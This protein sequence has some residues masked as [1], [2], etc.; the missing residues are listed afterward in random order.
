[1]DDCRTLYLNLIKRSLLNMIYGDKEVIYAAPRGQVKRILFSAIRTSG[2]EVV[3]P[4]S[5][6]PAV[7]A[8]GGD[9]PT[10][11]QTM[12][13]MARL[14]NIQYC[15]ETVLK[16]A[17]P[18]DL[19]ET[20]VW[21]GGATIFM[22]ALLKAYSVTDRLV[23][24]ADSFEGLPPADEAKYPQDAGIPYHTMKELMISLEKVQAN[25]ARYELLDDQVKFLKGWFRDTLPTAPM[26]QLAVMRLDGDMYESTMDGLN[27]LYPKLSV[28]GFVIIDDYGMLEPCRQAVDDY[29]AQ[30]GIQETI[31]KIDFAGVFW[32]RLA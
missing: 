13:S 28:G 24:V 21:R 9:W 22:R 1:M 3:R 27:A 19:I 16:D 23:Y 17:V 6:D 7:R 26:K 10:D 32:R 31:E 25:F 12:L 29:R 20:G 4:R 8:S 2:V 30:H 5:F 14:D 11:G 15:V 18:G